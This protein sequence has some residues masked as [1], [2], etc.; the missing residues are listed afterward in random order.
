MAY[1]LSSMAGGIDQVDVT[2]LLNE[3]PIE[4]YDNEGYA[5]FGSVLVPD[6]HSLC[7]QEVDKR[8]AECGGLLHDLHRSEAGD[9]IIG[10]A[11]QPT[12][13]R[14]LTVLSGNKLALVESVLIPFGA[15]V[16][17]EVHK[18]GLFAKVPDAR[19][20]AG[21]SLWIVL[22]NAKGPKRVHVGEARV[23]IRACEGVAVD[24]EVPVSLPV[25]PITGGSPIRVIVL[26]FLPVEFARE[27]AAA[28]GPVRSLR[29]WTRPGVGRVGPVS[30]PWPFVRGEMPIAHHVG[31]ANSIYLSAYPLAIQMAIAET[32]DPETLADLE[33]EM[34]QCM[35]LSHRAMHQGLRVEEKVYPGDNARL[36]A[37]IHGT[38]K[39]PI[40]Q[41][42]MITGRVELAYEDGTVIVEDDAGLFPP[43]WLPPGTSPPRRAGSGRV[44]GR[45]VAGGGLA[46]GR[47]VAGALTCAMCDNPGKQRCAACGEV[48][49]CG[50]ECQR[51]HWKQHKKACKKARTVAKHGAGDDAADSASSPPGSAAAS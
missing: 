36:K 33:F 39:G 49:Y 10:I 43:L 51:T 11:Y 38:E 34:Q 3:D 50:R 27:K 44:A 2:N 7:Q 4:V 45:P 23:T 15:D 18:E 40:V 31:S 19:L 28:L 5:S 6:R 47:R 17:A 29:E 22:D 41:L 37:A 32:S 35:G 26:R 8:A 21:I 14:K 30:L 12:L 24:S 25:D 1:D 42:N 13:L 20:V 16:A 46:G 9:W 48:F